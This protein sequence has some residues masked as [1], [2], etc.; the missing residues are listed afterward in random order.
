MA[1]NPTRAAKIAYLFSGLP[2]K[3]DNNTACP[4]GLFLSTLLKPFDRINC[5]LLFTIL[6]PYGIPN[7]LTTLIKA[8][9]T[10]MSIKVEV[11]KESNT[12]LY[13]VGVQQGNNTAPLLFWFVM[14]AFTDII[15]KNLKTLQFNYFS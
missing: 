1:V 9:Y 14:Q 8:L 15:E 13:L 2:F 3:P 12:I 11:G 10:V 5:N 4:H 7:S 6:K